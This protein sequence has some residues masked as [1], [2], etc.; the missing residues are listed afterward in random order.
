MNFDNKARDGM[1]L[2][3]KQHNFSGTPFTK[4]IKSHVTLNDVLPSRIFHSSLDLVEILFVSLD[5]V[6]S[7]NYS[8]LTVLPLNWSMEQLKP[9]AWPRCMAALVGST[10]FST[11]RRLV[12]P[13]ISTTSW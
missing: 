3:K 7:E 10:A 2:I 6:F 4:F 8:V 5:L 9:R 13:G 11:T 1:K 12:Q